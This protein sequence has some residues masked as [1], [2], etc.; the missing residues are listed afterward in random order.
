[1][2]LRCHPDFSKRDSRNERMKADQLNP[3]PCG[4]LV[5]DHTLTKLAA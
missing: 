5:I 4:V 3:A 2:N 1:M